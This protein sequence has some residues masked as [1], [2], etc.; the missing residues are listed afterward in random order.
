MDA[1]LSVPLDEDYS[2][3]VRRFLMSLLDELDKKD[4]M[5]EK[6]EERIDALPTRE[7]FSDFKNSLTLIGYND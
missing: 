2:Y 4:R 5:I 1:R 6:L 3:N 7:E